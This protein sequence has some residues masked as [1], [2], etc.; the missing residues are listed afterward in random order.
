[1]HSQWH[2]Y[3]LLLLLLLLLRRLCVLCSN[4]ICV[5]TKVCYYFSEATIVLPNITVFLLSRTNLGF[6]ARQWRIFN[7]ALI[8]STRR[9]FCPSLASFARLDV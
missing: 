4:F 2:L 7:A 8:R 5:R 3:P 6:K 1:L 9:F